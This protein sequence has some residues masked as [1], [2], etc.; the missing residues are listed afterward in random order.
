MAPVKY[1]GLLILDLAT[2]RQGCFLTGKTA[3]EVVQS[4]NEYCK[5][6]GAPKIL[7]S[8]LGPEFTAHSCA[9]ACDF[10]DIHH[11]VREK[12]RDT[13]LLLRHL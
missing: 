2:R 1:F 11:S 9:E 8:D 10:L 5:T 3:E 6:Y 4:L 7:V 12:P 13:Y